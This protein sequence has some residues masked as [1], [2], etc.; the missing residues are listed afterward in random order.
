MVLFLPCSLLVDTK[1]SDNCFFL[2]WVQRVVLVD[3]EDKA[4]DADKVDD[5]VDC[6][7]GVDKVDGMNWVGYADR[8]DRM[9]KDE[10]QVEVVG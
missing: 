8:V 1:P 10:D 9:D 3:R 7:D 2:Q 5:W 4:V 6:I